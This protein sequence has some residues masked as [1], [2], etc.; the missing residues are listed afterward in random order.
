MYGIYLPS[1]L[2]LAKDMLCTEFIH[3]GANCGL[4]QLFPPGTTLHPVH[5]A[6]NQSA[7]VIKMQFKKKNLLLERRREKNMLFDLSV[8]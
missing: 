1:V 8:S 3:T 6:R 7:F 2:H 4:K 5:M